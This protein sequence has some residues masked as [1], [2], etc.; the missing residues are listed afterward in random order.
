MSHE[1][2]TTDKRRTLVAELERRRNR[3]AKVQRSFAV[4]L[5]AYDLVAAD[6]RAAYGESE[7]DGEN[8][9]AA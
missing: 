4:V 9:T 3:I 6:L 2:P 7:H 8:T 5:G 1:N